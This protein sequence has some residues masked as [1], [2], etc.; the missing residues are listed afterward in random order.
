MSLQ[1][2]EAMSVD[3][4]ERLLEEDR[5]GLLADDAGDG[6][7]KDIAA[8]KVEA[9]KR[10]NRIAYCLWDAGVMD[11]EQLNAIAQQCAP[12]LVLVKVHAVPISHSR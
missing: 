6:T 5:R 10:L 12:Y 2:Y 1:D 9:A 8:K 3:E 7:T 11:R 4:L